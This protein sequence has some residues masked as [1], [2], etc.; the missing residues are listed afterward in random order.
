M[1]ELRP[2]T[3]RTADQVRHLLREQ[4]RPRWGHL[5]FMWIFGVAGMWLLTSLFSSRGAEWGFVLLWATVFV[6]FEAWLQRRQRARI[7]QARDSEPELGMITDLRPRTVVLRGASGEVAV[8]VRSTSGLR[9][10][11]A[12]WAAP[13]A[14]VGEHVVLVR[15]ELRPRWAGLVIPRGPAEPV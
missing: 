12:I 8:P 10:G 9:V 1:S 11:D 15:D 5:A 4:A 7:A 6:G 2:H 14:T 3:R 13:G